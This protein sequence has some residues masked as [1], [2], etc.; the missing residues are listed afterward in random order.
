M[1]TG[2]VT[3]TGTM[4]STVQI[5]R[6]HQMFDKFLQK[7]YTRP[8]RLKAHDPNPAHFLREG[9]VVEYGYYTHEEKEARRQKDQERIAREEARLQESD[10]SGKQLA[11]FRRTE[12]LRRKLKGEK[13]RGVQFVVRRVVTPFGMGLEQR[14]ERLGMTGPAT[15]RQESGASCAQDRVLTEIGENLSQQSGRAAIAG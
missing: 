11:K 9:D 15:R 6:H 8:L 3:R 5:T 1:Y 12:A 10:K 13:L 7:H 2:T 14:M 4:A